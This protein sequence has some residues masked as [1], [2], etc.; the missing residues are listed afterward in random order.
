[1]KGAL[2]AMMDED[3]YENEDDD[4]GLRIA[5]TLS[6]VT[7]RTG[8]IESRDGVGVGSVG[9]GATSPLGLGATDRAA[10]ARNSSSSAAGDSSSAEALGQRSSHTLQARGASIAAEAGDGQ[11]VTTQS[12]GA[13][14]S[15]A[16]GAGTDVALASVPSFDPRSS[17][18]LGGF[19]GDRGSLRVSVGSSADEAVDHSPGEL[20]VYPS[21]SREFASSGVVELGQGRGRSLQIDTESIS[22]TEMTV[23]VSARVS[24]KKTRSGGKRKTVSGSN[25]P[26]R[27]AA[28]KSRAANTPDRDRKSAASSSSQRGKKKK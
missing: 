11:H 25:S 7:I 17:E 2:K 19:A 8:S 21:Q 20:V 26:E 12:D 10:G 14:A 3:G 5:K 27:K 9:L 23:S 24:V 4:G 6:R 22:P 1:M 18:Q 16:A 28:R 13:T 15:K